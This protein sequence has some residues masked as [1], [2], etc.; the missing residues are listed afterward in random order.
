MVQCGWFGK[1]WLEFRGSLGPPSSLR[2]A[3][4]DLSP[5]RT[6]FWNGKAWSHD[7]YVA[8][9]LLVLTLTGMKSKT[10][11]CRSA[12][13]QDCPTKGKFVWLIK[14]VSRV[15]TCC[16]N[17]FTA[18]SFACKFAFAIES[19]S[20]YGARASLTANWISA[21][22][23]CHSSA[24]S[25]CLWD[26][27]FSAAT[28]AVEAS[29]IKMDLLRTSVLK[30]LI[31]ILVFYCSTYPDT[32]LHQRGDP[33]LDPHCLWLVLPQGV[34]DFLYEFP[35]WEWSFKQLFD[36]HEVFWRR[37]VLTSEVYFTVHLSFCRCF[38]FSSGLSYNRVIFDPSVL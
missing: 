34:W 11:W 28:S 27:W 31:G 22:C 5:N 29:C 12:S 36:S 21:S 25:C 9:P 32:F 8:A 23:L 1:L 35:M 30:C 7:S 10:S 3:T 37:M 13:P 14:D 24:S 15:H 26:A 19:C 20:L 33:L 2:S 16:S 6:C 18:W 38:M 17:I 4:G